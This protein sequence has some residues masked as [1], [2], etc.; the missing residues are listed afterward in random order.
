MKKKSSFAA[1]LILAIGSVIFL[2]VVIIAIIMN[3]T[4]HNFIFDYLPIFVALSG[5]PVCILG[6]KFTKK[7]HHVFIGLELVFWGIV[8]CFF[9]KQLLPFRFVQWWPV[10]GVSAGIFLFIAGGIC[11][12]SIKFRY[13]I[14]GLV[15]FLLGIWFMLFSF[16]IIKVPFHIVA[17]V[18]GPLFFIMAGISIIIF[19]MLQR[20]YTNLIVQDDESSEFFSEDNPENEKSDE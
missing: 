2:G 1:D 18:G 14:P 5:L 8:L 4:Q 17:L 13:F 15:L 3:D 12:K 20:K 10:I 9:M 19:F 7:I 6:I 16:G 11:Y